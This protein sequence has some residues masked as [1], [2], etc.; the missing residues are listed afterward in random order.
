MTYRVSKTDLE[1]IPSS[2]TLGRFDAGMDINHKTI[3]WPSLARK[4]EF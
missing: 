3:V 4:T 2:N 1:S